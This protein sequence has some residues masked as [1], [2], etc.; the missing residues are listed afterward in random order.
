MARLRPNVRRNL[1]LDLVL[2]VRLFCGSEEKKS[3]PVRRS[4]ARIDVRNSFR[5]MPC[6]GFLRHDERQRE[7]FAGAA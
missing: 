4:I 6:P 7:E 3:N 1:L 5:F 2:L